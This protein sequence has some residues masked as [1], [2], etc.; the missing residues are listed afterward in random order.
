MNIDTIATALA[1]WKSDENDF[2]IL[3]ASDWKWIRGL[4][5]DTMNDEAALSGIELLPVTL[6]RA[7]DEIVDLDDWHEPQP[8][9]GA[10]IS[11]L[12]CAICDKSLEYIT[13]HD[14]FVHIEGN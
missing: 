13:G 3:A 10:D 5:R 7:D 4:I 2:V 14:T 9:L 11:E 8:K 6:D 12:Q 1:D